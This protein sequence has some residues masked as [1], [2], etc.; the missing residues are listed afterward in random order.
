[1]IRRMNSRTSR[2]VAFVSLLG[3]I[4]VGGLMAAPVKAQSNN[5]LDVL[6]AMMTALRT[7][8]N[9]LLSIA[10]TNVRITPV[11][12]TISQ[13]VGCYAVNVSA[14]PRTIR[15]EIHGRGEPDITTTTLAP[16]AIHLVD[17]FFDVSFAAYCK[18]VVM[19][20]TRAD[21][22]G[23]IRVGPLSQLEPPLVLAAE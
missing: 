11:A 6:L 18:F 14:G 2:S 21:I 16:G 7:N 12:P 15:F 9:A 5:P 3:A 1:M 17:E 19:D 13:E 10:Q 4:L 8:V 20:G 22:R 23:S